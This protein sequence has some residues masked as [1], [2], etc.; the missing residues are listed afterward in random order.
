MRRPII[1][2]I[3]C[4]IGYVTVVFT[5]PQ[6]FS[7]AIKKLGMFVPAIYGVLV[8]A[9]FIAC[10]GLWYFKQWGVQWYVLS[11]FA[12]T[13][14]YLLTEQ[15]GALFYFNVCLSLIFAVILLRFYPKMNTNL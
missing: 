14:F 8:A 9:H 6:I 3:I 13:I 2:T 15:L 1:I 12:K 5:F 10:V 11:F 4:I 7:P